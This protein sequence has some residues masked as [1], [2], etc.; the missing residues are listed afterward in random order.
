MSQNL[1]IT[2][3]LS[4][5]QDDT[6]N[7]E[8]TLGDIVSSLEGR[9]FGPLLM[10]PALIAFLPTGALP[11]VPS[12]CGILIAL[13]AIQK[14]FGKSHPW[15]PSRLREVDFDRERF[16]HGVDKVTPVTQRIDKLF[17]PRLTFLFGPLISRFIAALCVVFGLMMIPLELIPMAAAIP[18]LAI[19]FAAI[20]LSTRDG[21]MLLL[22]LILFSVAGYWSW[23]EFGI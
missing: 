19:I 2:D 23:T 12:M 21:V 13:I 17:K 14:V 11:G 6:D 8:I 10:A 5:L 16:S 3:V 7:K 15:V 22:A 1:N 4:T 9:G 18:A 20:G